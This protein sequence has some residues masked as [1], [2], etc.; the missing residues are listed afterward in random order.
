MET[1]LTA[2]AE[3]QAETAAQEKLHDCETQIK[4]LNKQLEV[5]KKS[6][7]RKSELDEKIPKIEDARKTAED[8]W[9]DADKQLGVLQAEHKTL[10]VRIAELKQSLALPD[11]TSA[12][13]KISELQ[14]QSDALEQALTAALEQEKASLNALTATRAAIEQLQKQLETGADGDLDKL[15]AQLD[16]QKSRRRNWK[17]NARAFTRGS[18]STGGRTMGSTKSATNSKI[19]SRNTS[20]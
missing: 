9:N 18:R 20:G 2:A 13:Q 3:E 16:A 7:L 15:S 8:N 5:L 6:I 12:E 11:K 14:K 17:S 1:L 4:D 19:W 10:T